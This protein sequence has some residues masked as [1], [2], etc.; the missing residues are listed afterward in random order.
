[1]TG[2]GIPTTGP[3]SHV[4]KV[5][6]QVDDDQEIVNT[7]EGYLHEAKENRKSGENP[8][9]E[10]WRKN[11]DQYWN[12]HDFSQKAD[13]QAKETMPEVPAFVDRFAAAMKEALIASP[14]GFYTVNDP[15]DKEHDLSD[16][17]KRMTDVWLTTVGRN[18]NGA[19]IG[20][21]AMFEEQMKLAALTDRLAQDGIVEFGVLE[22]R[23]PNEVQHQVGVPRLDSLRDTA[24]DGAAALLRLHDLSGRGPALGGKLAHAAL[25]NPCGLGKLALDRV[26]DLYSARVE[27]AKL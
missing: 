10:Q 27:V 6:G 5:L 21:P 19:I 12:R 14:E 2:P 22:T 16:A 15:A 18:Q 9:D 8:R 3:Y 20:F 13:W 23:F 24:H 17:I 7:L 4:P 25:I 11:L 1:M 26:P